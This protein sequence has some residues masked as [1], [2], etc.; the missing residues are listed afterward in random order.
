M[1]I[2]DTHKEYDGTRCRAH[3]NV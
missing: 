2:D 3:Y 1:S